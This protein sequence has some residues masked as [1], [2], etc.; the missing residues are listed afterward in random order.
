MIARYPVTHQERLSVV[1]ADDYYPFGMTMAGLEYRRGDI[2][3]NDYLYQGKELNAEHDLNWYDF[4]ARMFDSGLGRWMVADPADQFASSYIG[5][6]NMP[7]IAVDPDGMYTRIGALLRSGF[8][9]SC[10]SN[11]TGAPKGWG[12]F[13]KTGKFDEFTMLDGS[14]E[15]IPDMFFNDGLSKY[16]YLPKISSWEPNLFQS[17]GMSNNFLASTS[18]SIVDGPWVSLQFFTPW[19]KATHLDG[20]QVVGDE[21]VEA[22]MNTASNALPY[23]RLS[24]IPKVT[25]PQFSAYFKGSLAKLP[26]K[27]RG[28]IIKLYNLRIIEKT[29]GTVLT[30]GKSIGSLVNSNNNK[31]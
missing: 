28:W 18:Y 16:A 3:E 10:I 29:H 24:K 14:V 2:Q 19:R 4:H 12:F 31:E 7:T 20:Q 22:F 30:V 5:M 9:F 25:A 21:G 26:P 8:C 13:E 17:W 11:P 15:S 1:Q 6:G 27:V 23:S